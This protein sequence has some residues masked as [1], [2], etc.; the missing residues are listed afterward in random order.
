MTQPAAATAQD[1]P[2]ELAPLFETGASAIMR[3]ALLDTYM[4]AARAG[5]VLPLISF[6]WGDVIRL[7]DIEANPSV[8]DE[9]KR[10]GLRYVVLDEFQVDIIVS[11]FNPNIREV[12]VKG[13]T[14]CGKGAAAGISI[15]LYFLIWNDAKIVISRDTHKRAVKVMF[16]EVSHW[17][18]K[19]AYRPVYCRCLDSSIV[20]QRSKSEHTCD[21]VNPNQPEGF[22]GTHSAHILFVF[23]EAT[24]SPLEPRFQLADTQCSKFLALANPRTNAGRFYDAFH[25][26]DDPDETQTVMSRYGY[27]RLVTVDGADMMNVKLKRL[28]NP[29]APKGGIV[30]GSRAYNH[31]DEIALDDFRKVQRIIPG[32]TGYDIWLA[33]CDD[34]DENWVNCFA[35]G[36]FMRED[37]QKQ[38]IRSAWVTDSIAAGERYRELERRRI[39][40]KRP[41]SAANMLLRRYMPIEACGLDVGGSKGGDPSV[42][43]IGGSKG[44]HAQH[45][46]NFANAGELVNWVIDTLHDSYG[47]DLRRGGVPIGIDA[48]GIGWGLTSMFRQRGV[49]VLEIRGNDPSDVD[50]KVYAN[51]RAEMYGELGARL[52]TTGRYQ[53]NPFLLPDNVKL[54]QELAAPEKVFA[55]DGIRYHI[56]PKRKVP[57]VKTEQLS[58][59]ERIGRSPDYGDSAA[60][61]FRAL[62]IKAADLGALLDRGFF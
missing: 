15:C 17:W 47:V 27:R 29:I 62:V 26:V 3:M 21:V 58:I 25:V 59:E 18:R 13:N 44:I 50:P 36:R 61:F 23:D 1:E 4:R 9:Y 31:G 45:A 43:T 2:D 37:R 33:H 8:I 60:Y 34:P 42:L 54:R 53:H 46:A 52:D 39:D 20:D 5:D 14:G 51:K 41:D 49:R 57:G 55:P 38:V 32:Q 24:A 7:A 56:T 10:A 6:L 19:M 28:E 22:T 12:W 11:L 48:I 16:G 40:R 35:H 30:I